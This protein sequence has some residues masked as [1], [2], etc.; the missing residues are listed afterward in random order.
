MEIPRKL[1]E[2]EMNKI[3]AD[4]SMRSPLST[5]AECATQKIRS[6]LKKELLSVHIVPAKIN[7]LHQIIVKSFHKAKIDYGE[8]VGIVAAMSIGEPVTQMTLN[9]FHFTGLADKNVTLGVPRMT[10]LLNATKKIKSPAM[11]LAVKSDDE[12]DVQLLLQRAIL[13]KTVADV[14]QSVER[15]YGTA[16]P[17]H[18]WYD[19][20]FSMF[21]YPNI[22]SEF[23]AVLYLNKYEMYKIDVSLSDIFTILTKH[24]DYVVLFSPI[25]ASEIHIYSKTIID[26]GAILQKEIS[27]LSNITSAS[28]SNA[29]SGTSHWTISCENIEVTG[30]MKASLSHCNLNMNQ[31]Q[32]NDM[33]CMMKYYGIEAARDF[34]FKE[35][36]QLI[37]FDGTYIDK[38]HIEVLVDYMCFHGTITP[39]SRF[40]IAKQDTGPFTKAT[41]EES[42]DNFTKS[43]IKGESEKTTSVS[44]AIGFGCVAKIGTGSFDILYKSGID[45]YN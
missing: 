33:W 43:C 1:T 45:N 16:P 28:I 34:L 19:Q 42:L 26:Y 14:V 12:I 15:Y 21:H 20:F 31:Y 22:P 11:Y 25:E 40:G 17:S 4:V 29:V 7:D 38:R 18:G 41:F 3:L 37:S 8:S 9:T 13:K 44:S 32:C 23:C 27:G 36:L 39:V 35:L 6:S 5:I 2:E 30:A 24:F 10:E